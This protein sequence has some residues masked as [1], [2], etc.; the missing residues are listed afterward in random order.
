[1]LSL[2]MKQTFPR[3]LP[4]HTGTLKRHCSALQVMKR[5]GIGTSN[6]PHVGCSWHDNPSQEI[7]GRIKASHISPLKL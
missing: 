7:L 2:Q 5:H 6:L 4:E 3:L 1:M